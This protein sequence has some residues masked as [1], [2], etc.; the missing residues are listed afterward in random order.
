MHPKLKSMLLAAVL[1]SGTTA[2]AANVR[3]DYDHNVN[4]GNYTTFTWGE[5]KTTN[6]L[7]ADRVKADIQ[8]DLESKGWHLVPSGGSAT[9]MVL[10]NVKNEQEVETMYNG[11]GGAWGGGWGW[12]GWR[13]FGG[14]FGPGGFGDSTSQVETQRVGHLVVDILDSSNHHLLFRGVTDRDLSDKSSKNIN[15]LSKDVHNILK[16]M[17]AGSKASS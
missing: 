1:L 8:K 15:N 14:G 13:G 12:G 6:P 3:T 4:F 17:P 10:D 7:N 2:F 5:V 11:M 16:K 9:V